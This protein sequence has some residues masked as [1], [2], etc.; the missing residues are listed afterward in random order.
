MAST[1]TPRPFRLHPQ[2]LADCHRL[3]QLRFCHLLLNRNAALPWFILVPETELSD[4]LDLPPVLRSKAMD[5]TA[6]IS[7][8]IKETLGYP[9]VNFAAI[10]NVVPQL[11]LHVIGRREGD[12][13]WP[14]P[15]WGHLE[16]NLSY[17]K[18]QLEDIR[19]GIEALG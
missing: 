7:G 10:G 4:L 8:F 9:K 19:R 5:D 6:V 1:P 2:L 15:V 3:G 11:H 12:P 13:C 17:S 14:S 16:E 18:A